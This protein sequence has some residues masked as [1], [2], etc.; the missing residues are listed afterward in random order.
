MNNIDKNI[1]QLNYFS[2]LK[3]QCFD[4]SF[5]FYAECKRHLF[6]KL[7]V[8]RVYLIYHAIFKLKVTNKYLKKKKKKVKA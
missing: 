3:T 8:V 4:Q 6:N 2:V 1:V 7:N 5:A